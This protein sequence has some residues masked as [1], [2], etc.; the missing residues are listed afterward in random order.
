MFW[1]LNPG[2]ETRFSA[3]VHTGLGAHSAPVQWVI[4]QG[5]GP[6]V[7]ELNFL[8]VGS[9]GSI[10]CSTG[11]MVRGSS[12]SG[13]KGF[14]STSKQPSWLWGPPS[15]LLRGSALVVELYIYSPSTPS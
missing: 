6:Y 13:K 1:V 4:K 5:S 3:P 10:A 12:P 11:W 8:T 9:M 7:L 2:V 15:P 14:S